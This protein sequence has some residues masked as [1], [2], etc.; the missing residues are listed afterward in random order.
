M[1][2]YEVTDESRIKQFESLLA[3][4]D[5]NETVEHFDWAASKQDPF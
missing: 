4:E 1:D 5:K 2:K 3:V